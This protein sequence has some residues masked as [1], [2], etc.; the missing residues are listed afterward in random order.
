MGL[1][2]LKTVVGLVA[3][4][5]VG[6]AAYPLAAFALEGVESVTVE[7]TVSGGAAVFTLHYN[8]SVT[9]KDVDF[10]VE[11]L[12]PQGA[13]LASGHA[14]AA[15]LERGGSIEVRLPAQALAGA[16]EVR[17]TI[18]GDIA[19]IYHFNITSTQPVEASG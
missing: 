9:L 17:V 2:W 6:L 11:L 3:L 15:R 12:S 7:S 1:P 13:V 19:G 16:A 8:G 4:V 10:G 14:G 5:A 18:T